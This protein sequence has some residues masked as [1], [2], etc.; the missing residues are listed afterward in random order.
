MTIKKHV[1]PEL[2]E[3][4]SRMGLYTKGDDRL[5]DHILDSGNEFVLPINPSSV[6][7]DWDTFAGGAPAA[8]VTLSGEPRNVVACF[9]FNVD[10]A[11]T[12]FAITKLSEGATADFTIAADELTFVTD[13]TGLHCI[14]IYLT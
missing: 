10:F 1:N 6:N 3:A 7:I 11:G 12:A 13:Q 14:I 9:A 2:L 5:Y 4:L 8:T